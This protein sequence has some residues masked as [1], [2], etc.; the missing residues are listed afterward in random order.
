MGLAIKID[1]SSS[2]I[3]A[4]LHLI[5]NSSQA[6]FP[7]KARESLN[8]VGDGASLCQHFLCLGVADHLYIRT[9]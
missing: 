4:R 8:T 7:I 2:L 9:Y 3:T 6:T 5:G 1:F